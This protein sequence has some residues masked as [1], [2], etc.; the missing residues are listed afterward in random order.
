M[1]DELLL[2]GLRA[3]F[4]V[5]LLMGMPLMLAFQ[6][7]WREWQRWHRMLAANRARVLRCSKTW[8]CLDVDGH[9][10]PCLNIKDCD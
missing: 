10:G 8:E 6:E 4:V 7:A 1:S 2:E 5:G 9:P 3:G